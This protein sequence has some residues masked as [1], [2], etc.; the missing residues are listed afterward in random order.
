MLAGLAWVP[1]GEVVVSLFVVALLVL[2]IV[3]MFGAAVGG[4]EDIVLTITIKR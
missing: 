2:V 1:V 3:W 4:G